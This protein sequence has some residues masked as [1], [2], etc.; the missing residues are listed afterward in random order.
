MDCVGSREC[1]QPLRGVQNEFATGSCSGATPL[2]LQLIFYLL[3]FRDGGINS[4]V[5][6]IGFSIVS[7]DYTTVSFCTCV[8]YTSSIPVPNYTRLTPQVV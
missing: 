6:V 7:H 1:T 2:A 8:Y 5:I 3:I 4:P